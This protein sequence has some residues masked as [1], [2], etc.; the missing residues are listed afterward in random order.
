MPVVHQDPGSCHLS[1]AYLSVDPVSSRPPPP[2]GKMAARNAQLISSKLQVQ[3]SREPA[4]VPAFSAKISPC[5]ASFGRVMWYSW[6]GMRSRVVPP[7]PLQEVKPT[8]A[9]SRK[10]VNAR[11]KVGGCYKTRE[12][13]DAVVS[14]LPHLLKCSLK[15]GKDSVLDQ[16]ES[17]S[18]EPFS[19]LGPDLWASVFICTARVLLSWFGQKSPFTS[20]VSSLQLSIHSHPCLL[21]GHKSL[22]ASVGFQDEPSF[23][24]RF[25]FPLLH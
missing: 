19:Q 9:E 12:W 15:V 23:T 3:C 13:M 1:S 6:F 17:G 25:L 5:V 7:S 4:S 16:T 22:V 8:W 2:D 11:W 20:D 14:T 18:S 21:L 24:W 10:R